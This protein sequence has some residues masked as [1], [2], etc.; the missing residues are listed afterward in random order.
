MPAGTFHVY[1]IGSNGVAILYQSCAWNGWPTAVPA[2]V[3]LI[4]VHPGGPP[5][6]TDAELIWSTPSSRSP[7]TTPAGGATCV[8]FAIVDLARN[9]GCVGPVTVTVTPAPADSRLPL[10]STARLRTCTVPGRVG[11][12]T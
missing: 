3:S 4:S 10:S 8:L 7:A 1:A 11:L 12:N 2:S 5:T 9:V 6:L